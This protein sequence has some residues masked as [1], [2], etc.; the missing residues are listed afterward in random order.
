MT[1]T[2]L[3]EAFRLLRRIPLL[4]IPGIVGGL[5]AGALWLVLMFSG[6]FFAGRLLIISAL[7]LL[8]FITGSLTLIKNDG[9]DI[10][11]MLAGGRQYY[12]RVLLPL[13]VVTFMI[14]LVFVLVVLTL[15]L[16]GTT[17]DPALI[18][19]LT[20]GVTIPS[21]LFTFF[22]GTAAVFEDRK[23]FDSIQRSIELV[24]DNFIR[25]VI[26]FLTCAFVSCAVIFTLMVIWEALLYSRLEPLTRYTEAQLQA[27]TPDQLLALI[28]TDGI[29]V[30]AVILVIA[31][32][33]LVP[34]IVSYQA[35][36]FRKLA[37]EGGT[38]EIRQESGEYD[39]KGRWY[40]Y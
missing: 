10:R 25:A 24:T 22:A 8:F 5:L 15:T 28:G 31:G 2:E 12:F 9:G 11:S 7:A 27:F 32:L 18:V 6:I 20:F 17:P 38:V 21:I 36:F 35:C 33:V 26:F 19:F 29:W 13:L 3:R 1:M 37:A 23:V 14:V 39:S 30:T 4:W 40:K 16:I 34:V